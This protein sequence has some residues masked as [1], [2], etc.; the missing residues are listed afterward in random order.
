MSRPPRWTRY[1]FGPLPERTA[2]P[3]HL[4]PVRVV[5][6][7]APT[8]LSTDAFQYRLRYADDREV[9]DYGSSRWTESPA[10]LFTAR[11]REEIARAGRVLDSNDGGPAV[12]VLKVE[13]DQFAQVFDQPGTSRG[14]V[15]LRATLLRGSTL[16]AQQSFS[17]AS[18]AASADAAGGAKALAEASDAAIGQIVVWLASQNL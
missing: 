15:R 14:V 11:L 1:D 12:P 9:H 18:P 16:I 2:A 10:Q 4:L 5:A 6:V 8:A 3:A 7:T 17:T 13:L